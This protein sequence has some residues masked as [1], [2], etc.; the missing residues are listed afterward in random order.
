MYVRTE[1]RG[2]GVN[3]KILDALLDWARESGLTEVRLEVYNENQ[4]AVRAYDKA[5]FTANLLEMRM[6]LK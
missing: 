4:P 1:H 3:Q 6:E 5:G 2:K